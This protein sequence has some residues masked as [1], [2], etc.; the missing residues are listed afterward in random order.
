[1]RIGGE[2]RM[3]S[4]ARRHW[5]RLAAAIGAEPEAVVAL[6]DDI[7][8]QAPDLLGDVC[9]AAREEGADHP[10]LERMQAEITANARACRA[11][12][13]VASDAA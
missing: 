8:A 11:R 1:M 12:L 7:A 3:R 5:A 2:Y 10:V 6:A 4:I 13:A 9:R